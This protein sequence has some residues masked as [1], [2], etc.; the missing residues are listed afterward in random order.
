VRWHLPYKLSS[1]DLIEMM[2]ERGLSLACTTILRWVQCYAAFH[3]AVRE[4]KIDGLVPR[5]TK[6]RS[7]KYLN[8]LI[9]QDHRDIK[10][11]VNV[12]A[13]YKLFRNAALVIAGIERSTAFAKS[14]LTYK[15]TSKIPLRRQYG[16]PCSRLNEGADN[17]HTFRFHH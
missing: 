7:S 15:S 13:G 4:M 11:R 16:M 14:S 6:L 2:A 8:K 1:R 10:S 9:E 3:Y 5:N 12:M 17:Q